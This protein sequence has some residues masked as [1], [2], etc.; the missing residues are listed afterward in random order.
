MCSQLSQTVRISHPAWSVPFPSLYCTKFPPMVF[1]SCL[2]HVCLLDY[3]LWKVWN[4]L[5]AWSS[6]NVVIMSL[7]VISGT[8]RIQVKGVEAFGGSDKGMGKALTENV[9]ILVLTCLVWAR[10]SPLILWMCRWGNCLA[11]VQVMKCSLQMEV[12]ICL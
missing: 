9:H 10:M 5:C 7:F 1:L 6:I 11:Q 4:A 8:I 2:R 12:A 3:E